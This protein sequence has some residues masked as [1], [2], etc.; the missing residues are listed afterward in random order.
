MG[1]KTSVNQ[2][3]YF[4]WAKYHH[5]TIA[6]IEQLYHFNRENVGVRGK[7]SKASQVSL[8]GHYDVALLMMTPL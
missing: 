4:F 5:N 7:Q 8:D 1:P 6:F 3:I 2:S